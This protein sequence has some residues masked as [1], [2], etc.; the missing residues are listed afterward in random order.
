MMLLAPNLLPVRLLRGSGGVSESGGPVGGSGV[1]SYAAE[2][3]STGGAG[4][5]A[6]DPTR[7]VF[8]QK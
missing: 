4:E 7:P 8:M 3:T 6:Y 1:Q 5:E 2:R